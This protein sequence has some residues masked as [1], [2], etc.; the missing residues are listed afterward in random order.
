MS[1]NYGKSKS[2][3]FYVDACFARKFSHRSPQGYLNHR[4]K[5]ASQHQFHPLERQWKPS[6]SASFAFAERRIYTTPAPPHSL[7]GSR[8]SFLGTL[9]TF[10]A[11]EKTFLRLNSSLIKGPIGICEALHE[12]LDAQIP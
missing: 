11:L 5:K 4:F 3:M 12:T 10:L 9:V 8:R 2:D 7:S 1:F 6:I